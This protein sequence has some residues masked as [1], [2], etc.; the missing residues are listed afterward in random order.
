VA[1]DA[2][3]AAPPISIIAEELGYYPVYSNAKSGQV[4]YMP[5]R[6][7]R[8]STPQAVE[9]ARRLSSSNGNKVYTAYWC[10]HCARQRE[11]FGRQAW[12]LLSSTNNDDATTSG[13]GSVEVECA[14]GGYRANPALCRRDGIDGYPT[15]KIQGQTF[16][17]EVPLAVLAQA[18]GDA[19]FRDDVEQQTVLPPLVGSAAACMPPKKQ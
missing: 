10:P 16:S 8:D 15:W 4:V 7:Q 2:A 1:A 18:V 11:L 5:K 3:H 14:P 19:E 13:T 9:L 17:G 6:I 12:A